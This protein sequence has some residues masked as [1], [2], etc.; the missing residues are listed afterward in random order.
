[1]MNVE[2]LKSY[3]EAGYPSIK[4]ARSGKK[5]GGGIKGSAAL[6]MASLTALA[7]SSCNPDAL[8]DGGRLSGEAT[9]EEATT[10]YLIPEGTVAGEDWYR[11]TSEETEISEEMTRTAGI[12]AEEGWVG[13]KGTSVEETEETMFVGDVM[14]TE[15][16]V[17][18]T[19][20]PIEVGEVVP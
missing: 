8:F 11:S 12:V 13:G 4:D 10:T 14:Y 5:Y 9:A 15:T 7:I 17:V 19:E 16:G 3:D 6:I 1:M 2:P 18:S 20:T